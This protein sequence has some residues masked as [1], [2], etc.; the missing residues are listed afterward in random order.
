MRFTS[1]IDS[2]VPR[3]EEFERVLLELQF[4][5]EQDGDETAEGAAGGGS[6]SEL[7]RSVDNLRL[8]LWQ[9]MRPEHLNEEQRRMLEMHVS[10]R[11]LKLLSRRAPPSPD[12]AGM[13]L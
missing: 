2:L 8:T 13:S 7:K 11:R 10:A 1:E 3:L 9:A 12:G 6:L 4:A 5:D